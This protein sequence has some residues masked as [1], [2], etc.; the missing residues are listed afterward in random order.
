MRDL[1]PTWAEIDREAFSR[2]VDAIARRLPRGSQLIAVLKADAYGHGAVEMAKLCK[3]DR[4]AMIATALLEESLELRQAGI[5]LPLFV[6][7][8]LSASQIRIALD[9]RITI[10]IVGPEE[11]EIVCGLAR[12]R[13]VTVHLKLDTGMGRMGVTEGELARVIE[14][15]RSTPRLRV[16]AVYTHFANADDPSDTLTDVQIEKFSAMSAAIRAPR[17]HLAN[18]AATLRGLVE[19][20]DFVR[21]GVALFGVEVVGSRLDPVMRWRTEIMRLKDLP[22][23]HGI[24]YGTTFHTL[25]PSRIATLPV[26]YADGYD[27]NLSNNAYVLVRGRRA[28]VVGRI[29]MDLVTIDV[30]DIPEAR[31]GDE[32]ILMGDG[33]SADELAKRAGT[34]SYDVLCRIS[35]RVPRLYK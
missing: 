16:E 8:P 11:L 4:V 13:D 9:Q 2:N 32:V 31:Y 24:G 34:I 25:R 22:P 20:G 21:V 23:G 5:E 19:P 3:P 33:I 30:T 6:L 14:M 7:G 17:H 28:P 1:R 35:K 27:R 15:I 12:D 29:S 10:G 18:S 26:G